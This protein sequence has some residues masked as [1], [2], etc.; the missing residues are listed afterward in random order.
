VS[1]KKGKGKG[2]GQG[3]VA[4][5]DL[6]SSDYSAFQRRHASLTWVGAKNTVF[7]ADLL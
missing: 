5:C 1:R 2:K 6:S 3:Q 4:N 7:R